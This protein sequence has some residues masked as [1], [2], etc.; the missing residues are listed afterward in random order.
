MNDP[1]ALCRSPSVPCQHQC[2]LL[3]VFLPTPHVSDE[4]LD[5]LVAQAN[6]H[7]VGPGGPS[8]A[9]LALDLLASRN[10]LR[11]VRRLFGTSD[12]ETRAARAM[13]AWFGLPVVTDLE[14]GAHLIVGQTSGGDLVVASVDAGLPITIVRSE[15]QR[16]VREAYQSA[17]LPVPGDR[18]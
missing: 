3:P 13:P 12:V 9:E 16:I 7:A 15:W 18:P 5:R 10:A 6:I 11:D 14:G 2:R 17:G 8:R 1:V 4:A